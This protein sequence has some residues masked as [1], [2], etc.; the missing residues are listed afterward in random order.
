[1]YL[2]Y[3]QQRS[4]NLVCI[5]I[6]FDR[7]GF[8]ACRRLVMSRRVGP[9]RRPR[10]R[11]GY[12]PTCTRPGTVT[13]ELVVARH[14]SRVVLGPHV[15]HGVLGAST[16][17]YSHWPVHGSHERERKYLGPRMPLGLT[18]TRP[19]SLWH[20]HSLWL[21]RRRTLKNSRSSL[22]SCS[23]VPSIERLRLQLR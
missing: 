4:L 5:Y 2:H 6:R 10:A 7:F 16:T 15:W 11:H 12:G 17:R 20:P 8:A 1:M 22:S 18:I 9:V 23:G 13:N 21:T 3:L 19:P 14:T